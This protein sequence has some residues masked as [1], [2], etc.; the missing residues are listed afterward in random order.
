M[1]PETKHLIYW[2]GVWLKRLIL[3]SYHIV[4]RQAYHTWKNRKYDNS[5]IGDENNFFNN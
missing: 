4:N 2:W 5:I 1:N 3:T